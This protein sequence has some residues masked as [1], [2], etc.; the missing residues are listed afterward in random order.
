MREFEAATKG[1]RRSFLQ[2]SAAATVAVQ[3]RR[4]HSSEL[5]RALEPF[6]RR[7][8]AERGDSVSGVRLQA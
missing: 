1:S 8:S 2:L 6:V 4:V 7:F 3:D 5:A